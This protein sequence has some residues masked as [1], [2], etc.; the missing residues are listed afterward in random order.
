ME[1]SCSCRY[2]KR[3][4][5]MVPIYRKKGTPPSTTKIKKK[6]KNF[7]KEKGTIV[8]ILYICNRFSRD[9]ILSKGQIYSTHLLHHFLTS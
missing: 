5:A 7:H 1:S 6:R 2:F 8:H 3:L 9:K 4:A